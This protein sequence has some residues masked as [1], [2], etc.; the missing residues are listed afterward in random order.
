MPQA[1]AALPKVFSRLVTV[2]KDGTATRRRERA[3]YWRDNP[4]AQRLIAHLSDAATDRPPEEK[5]RLLVVT[6][7]DA[8]STVEVAH[9]ALLREWATL[10]GWI[11]EVSD[12]LR[13]REQLETEAQTWDAAGRPITCA[14]ATSAWPPPAR[15][16]RRPICSA[17][18][19]ETRCREGS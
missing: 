8:E 9:E 14:G 13:L 18:W 15:C 4:A 11:G 19:S 7:T 6:G 5:N 12:A 2:R 3:D 17:S 10:A 16:W 1:Q